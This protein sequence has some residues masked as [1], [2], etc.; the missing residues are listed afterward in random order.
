MS[1]EPLDAPSRTYRIGHLCREFGVSA[2]TLRYYEELGLLTPD[3]QGTT[4][5]YS[6]K[7]RA[8]LTLILQ[9]R[10]V[11]MPL[12]EV[13]HLLDLHEREGRAALHADAL[14]IFRRQLRLLEARREAAEK[15]ITVLQSAIARLSDQDEARVPRRPEAGPAA[16][17]ERLLARGPE[18]WGQ[19]RAPQ[20]D[21]VQRR[22]GPSHDAE[23][24]PAAQL[25]CDLENDVVRD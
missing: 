13:G 2:R 5:L 15:G 7:D 16:S 1:V 20:A 10:A 22:G 23:V 8:R 21:L 4:R 18:W 3:R 9:G 24:P 12:A 14:S 11:G 19:G 25:I 17:G 6:R